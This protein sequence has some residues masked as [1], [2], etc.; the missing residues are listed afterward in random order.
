MRRGRG[1]FI[2]E[3]K[4]ISHAADDTLFA[5]NPSTGALLWESVMT[6][7]RRGA[8]PSGAPVAF[9]GSVVVPYNCAAWTA[10]DPCHMSAYDADNGGLLWRW[11]AS[12]TAQDSMNSTWGD[13]PQIYP[14]EC[15]RNMSPWMTPAADSERGLFIFGVRSSAPQQPQPAGT[16]GK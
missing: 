13:D 7:F 5:L 8:Q 4:L 9:G 2:Y 12:P 10:A 11:H 15:R 1:V 3:D 16:N 14:L 6:D